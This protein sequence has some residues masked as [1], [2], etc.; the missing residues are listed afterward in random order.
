MTVLDK[1]HAIRA[2]KGDV[3]TKGLPDNI[4]SKFLASDQTLVHAIE[5]AY[6]NFKTLKQNFL[7]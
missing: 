3:L 6:E 2:S 1:L 5:I 7:S 4:V